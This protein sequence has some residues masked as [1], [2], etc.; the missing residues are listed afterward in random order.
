MVFKYKF[1]FKD[2]RMQ[3]GRDSGLSLSQSLKAENQTSQ[4][5]G[6]EKMDVATQGEHISSFSTFS[7]Q[8]LNGLD[9]IH[10]NW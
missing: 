9:D 3:G 10:L 5:Q 8:A 6:E 4:C 2:P 7:I 1:E